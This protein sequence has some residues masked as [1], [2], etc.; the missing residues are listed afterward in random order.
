MGSEH[1][2]LQ[3]FVGSEAFILSE[4]GASVDFPVDKLQGV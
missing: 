2:G 1:G 3:A 4:I